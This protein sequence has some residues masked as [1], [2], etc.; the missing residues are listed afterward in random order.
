MLH[1]LKV[2]VLS[3]VGQD[4]GLD[5][6]LA[7]LRRDPYW[8]LP[9]FGSASRLEPEIEEPDQQEDPQPQRPLDRD[10]LRQPSDD[11]AGEPAVEVRARAWFMTPYGW[12]Y[13]TR[14]SRPGT[15]T[16]MVDGSDNHVDPSVTSIVDLKMRIWGPHSIGLRAG[17][18]D[19]KGTGT[20]SENFI[21]HGR[22]FAAGRQVETDLDFRVFDFEYLYAMSLAPGLTLTG[23]LGA[24]YWEFSGKVTTVDA[25]PRVAGDREFTSG[26]WLA[27][28]DGL[29]DVHENFSLRFLAVGG[30]ETEGRHFYELEAGALLRLGN[31]IAFEVGYRLYQIHFQQSTNEADLRYYGPTLGVELRF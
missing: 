17:S 27:G 31:R 9:Q 7:R 22:T 14:G 13:I 16:R 26:F 30:I 3:L 4:P 5:E 11:P 2:A 15:A 25:G 18:C 24:Q 12:L 28:V 8:P 19:T 21:Y 23:H 20:V 29:W 6:R 10:S 1:C